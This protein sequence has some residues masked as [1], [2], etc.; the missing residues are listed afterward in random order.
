MALRK[1]FSFSLRQYIHWV[2][3]SKGT[4]RHKRK[5]PLPPGALALAQH[6]CSGCCSGGRGQRPLRPR[7]RHAARRGLWLHR[8]KPSR[9]LRHALSCE[10][11]RDYENMAHT[12][13]FPPPPHS[14]QR[15]AHCGAPRLSPS[16]RL[17]GPSPARAPPSSRGA[18]PAHSKGRH[19]TRLAGR[20]A[21]APG[22]PLNLPRGPHF[23]DS[24]ESWQRPA[25]VTYFP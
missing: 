2:R 20:G 4:E 14:G 19:Q 25:S 8:A 17:E 23:L 3:N 22:S 11:T 16:V 1:V 6:V 18:H 10:W 13:H 15:P 12:S 5:V 21:G 24:A 9:R 7:R